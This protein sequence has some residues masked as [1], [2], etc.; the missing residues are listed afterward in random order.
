MPLNKETQT[1]LYEK[2]CASSK[3]WTRVA[4]SISNDVK[5][6][7]MSVWLECNYWLRET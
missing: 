5:L 6:Y 2:R 4:D 7:A 1:Q 3:I